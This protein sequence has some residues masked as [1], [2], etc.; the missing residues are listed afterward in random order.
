M[1]GIVELF[2]AAADPV[3]LWEL[4]FAFVIIFVAGC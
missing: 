2:V 1:D 4:L 3:P